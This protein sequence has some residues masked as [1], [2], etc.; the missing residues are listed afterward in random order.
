MSIVP[1]NDLAAMG[2]TPGMLGPVERLSLPPAT[3]DQALGSAAAVSMRM[4]A[5]SF[6][7]GT[8]SSA[9]PPDERVG[10]RSDVLQALGVHLEI[11][12]AGRILHFEWA[13]EAAIQV[14]DAHQRARP[15]PTD[16][17]GVLSVPLRLLGRFVIESADGIPLAL[18][19]LEQES[20]GLVPLSAWQ[21]APLED[22]ISAM[23][24][25]WLES[26][27]ARTLPGADSWTRTALAGMIARLT[28]GGDPP[29]GGA[30]VTDPL[31]LLRR[32]SRSPSMAPRAWARALDRPQLAAIEEHARRRAMA[33]EHDLDDLLAV[34]P[35]D[36]DGIRHAWMQLCHRRDDLEGVRVLLREA[37]VGSGLDESLRHTDR[38][39]RAMRI[40]LG[41]GISTDDER[42]RRVALGDPAAWWG[43]P[44]FEVRLI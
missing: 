17:E 4:P 5:A 12:P 11:E 40:N 34:L 25:G 7:A 26:I 41:D 39:G 13:P 22:W 6:D 18:G 15:Y 30:G 21:G 42:L 27:V 1:K 16:T 38:A 31:M 3:V 8:E 28:Q 35:L 20:L 24:D 14:R 44:D 29:A 23:T 9:P 19:V 43:D 37:G 33:L 2:L 10:A 32:V 36:A